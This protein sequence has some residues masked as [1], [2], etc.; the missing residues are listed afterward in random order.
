MNSQALQKL[1]TRLLS[2]RQQLEPAQ[3]GRYKI[4][5]TIHPAGEKMSIV[6]MRDAI[7]T[8]QPRTEL[9]LTWPTAVHYLRGPDG[10]WMSDQPCE[11]VQMYLELASKAQGRV[12]IGGLGLGVLSN[13]V[14]QFKD[15]HVTTVER[16]VPVIALMKP[17][18][19]GKVVRANIYTFVDRLKPDMFDVAL[20]DTW[21]GTGEWVWFEDVVP[22][23]RKLYGK[24]SEVYCWHEETLRSQVWMGLFRAVN[25]P[26]NIFE[27]IGQVPKRAWRLG[28]AQLG[29]GFALHKNTVAEDKLRDFGYLLKLEEENRKNP[30]LITFAR[31][32]LLEVGSPWW[33]ETFGVHWDS[34]LRLAKEKKAARTVYRY[35]NI[36]RYKVGTVDYEASS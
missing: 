5:R 17:Y 8:G 34:S 7:F 24:V 29:I 31:R 18:N 6:S 36:G 14:L 19:V 28:L 22:L 13:M 32:F 35:D 30:V 10:T 25:M 2:E 11:L 21:Q 9:V 15:V 20:L 4:E 33:E 1:A 27:G 16:S 26:M 23:R 3:V 12:L